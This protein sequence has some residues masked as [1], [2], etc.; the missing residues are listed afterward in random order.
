MPVNKKVTL[1][2]SLI[3]RSPKQKRTLQALGLRKIRQSVTHQDSETLRG[4][5]AVVGPFVTVEDAKER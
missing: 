2:R 4:M 5:L 1:V 3:G